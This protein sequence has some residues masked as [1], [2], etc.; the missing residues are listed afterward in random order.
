[1]TG[2]DGVVEGAFLERGRR[3]RRIEQKKNAGRA[4]EE[5]EEKGDQ[6]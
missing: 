3:R 4:V 1:L 6:E 2:E 5:E